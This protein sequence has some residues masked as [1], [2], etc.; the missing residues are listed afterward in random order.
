[1]SLFKSSQV[2]NYSPGNMEKAS[3]RGHEASPQS[4]LGVGCKRCSSSKK[5]AQPSKIRRADANAL[6]AKLGGTT[7]PYLPLVHDVPLAE[8]PRRLHTSYS[9][10]GE[11]W[12]S[13]GTKRCFMCVVG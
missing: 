6:L 13:E 5:R 7:S 9:A 11:F 2:K 1:M 3:S 8:M 12:G 4:G 10:P